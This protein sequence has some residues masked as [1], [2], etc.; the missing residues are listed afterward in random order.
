MEGYDKTQEGP[1][2]DNIPETGVATGRYFT[3]IY[4]C[5]WEYIRDCDEEKI[6]II[7]DYP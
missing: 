5:W 7:G 6:W 4:G 3:D 2:I 1:R